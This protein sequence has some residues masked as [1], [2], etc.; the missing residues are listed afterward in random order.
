[1]DLL[2]CLFSRRRG[3]ERKPEARID[4]P[5]PRDHF[6]FDRSRSPR[7]DGAWGGNDDDCIGAASPDSDIFLGSSQSLSRQ[8]SGSVGCVC[9]CHRCKCCENRCFQSG[10]QQ[11]MDNFLFSPLS[12]LDKKKFDEMFAD[13]FGT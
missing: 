2:L 13:M 9:S 11:K 12:P 4:Q 3:R 10:S 1:M 5:R 7:R 6:Q 8:S